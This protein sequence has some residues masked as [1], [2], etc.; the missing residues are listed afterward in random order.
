[1]FKPLGSGENSEIL[2]KRNRERE[3]LGKIGNLEKENE[4]LRRKLEELSSKLQSE[5]AE[6]EKRAFE[7]GLKRGREEVLKNLGGLLEKLSKVTEEV[8]TSSDETFAKVR[9]LI[10]EVVF[11]IVN[12]LL[13]EVRNDS[14]NAALTSIR[15][16][17]SNFLTTSAGV[18]L[19]YLNPDDLKKLE[20][21]IRNQP[22]LQNFTD[23]FQLVFEPDPN[24]SPGDV[25][26]KTEA[27]DIDGRLRTKLEELKNYLRENLNV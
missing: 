22:E 2:E 9:D 16:I 6:R 27:I 1:M 11:E 17:V 23:R 14:L 15:E 20:E 3:L 19:V 18:K 4:L 21:L 26:V 12:K 10:I 24:L 5:V 7:E 8:R 25:I 13:P